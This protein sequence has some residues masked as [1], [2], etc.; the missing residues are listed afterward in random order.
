MR[1]A[2]HVACTREMINA[3]YIVV[4]KPERKGP[5]GRS[6]CRWDGNIKVDR[7]EIKCE[8]VD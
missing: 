6:R 8:D 1:C 5:L 7:K 2:E 4:R 3:Y